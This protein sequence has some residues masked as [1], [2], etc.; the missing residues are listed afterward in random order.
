M[1]ECPICGWPEE[2]GHDKQ[3]QR[4]RMMEEIRRH[5]ARE[6][7]TE[8]AVIK[9][10]RSGQDSGRIDFC[11]PHERIEKLSAYDKADL[12]LTA[13]AMTRGICDLVKMSEAQARDYMAKRP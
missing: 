7:E 4:D 11:L 2:V 12:V 5:M 6:G 8:Y 10:N 13:Y 3:C 9:R 1:N